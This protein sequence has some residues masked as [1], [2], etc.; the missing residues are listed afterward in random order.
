MEYGN[1]MRPPDGE[2]QTRKV[3][4][5][6]VFQVSIS[7][8][9]WFGMPPPL[10]SET[11]LGTIASLCKDPMVPK[12][13]AA[14]VDIQHQVARYTTTLD[15]QLEVRTKNALIKLFEQDLDCLRVNYQDVWS[16]ALDIE[17]LGAKLYLYG[18]SFVSA[19]PNNIEEGQIETPE[20]LSRCFLYRGFAA[21]VRLLHTVRH[22][23]VAE[24]PRMPEHPRPPIVNLLQELPGRANYLRQLGFLP[25]QFFRMVAFANFYLLWFLAVDLGASEADKDLA[26]NYVSGTHRLFMSFPNTPE[27]IRYGNTLEVL[28]RMPS[29]TNGNPAL[30]VNSRLGASFMYDIVRNVVLYREATRH[31]QDAEVPLPKYCVEREPLS[32]ETP[33][34][35]PNR[36]R[37]ERQYSAPPKSI[38]EMDLDSPHHTNFNFEYYPEPDVTFNQNISPRLFEDL[39]PDEDFPWGVW[40]DALYDSLGM[41]LDVSHLQSYD[42]VK[43]M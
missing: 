37:L 8:S 39:T 20:L 43:Y 13:I 16:E 42:E 36:P 10:N 2:I 14:H 28:G 19:N 27:Y 26:K 15:G 6:A 11:Y 9:S 4:W 7:L 33:D 5:L 34:S 17:L 21:A 23:N 1:P 38:Q 31:A 30:R 35:V 25:K 22:L 41:N 12:E 40:D 29:I 18:M 32:M 24:D 3:T